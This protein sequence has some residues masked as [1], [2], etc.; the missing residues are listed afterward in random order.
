MEIVGGSP[1]HTVSAGCIQFPGRLED[2]PSASPELRGGTATHRQRT[3]ELGRVCRQGEPSPRLREEITIR[4]RRLIEL[5]QQIQHVR[6]AAAPALHEIERAWVEAGL[7]KLNDL[8]AT[9]SA[10]ARRDIQ[11]HLDDLRMEPAP[12][13]GE[14]AVRMTGRA[15]VDGLLGGE[16]AVRPTIGCGDPI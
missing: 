2:Q 11:K 14:R 15:K 8:L 6:S 3:L 12:E 7:K 5:D 1:F 13:L 9:D 4:E 10:G 16:E